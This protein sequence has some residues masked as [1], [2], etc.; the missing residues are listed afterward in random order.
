MHRGP[1]LVCAIVPFA[2]LQ[3]D[4]RVCSSMHVRTNT[5]LHVHVVGCMYTSITLA[6]QVRKP[7]V[8]IHF[9]A[10]PTPP[11]R[12]QARH[13]KHL[14]TR[15]PCVFCQGVHAPVQAYLSLVISVWGSVCVY[16]YVHHRHRV[17][18]PPQPLP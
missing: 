10:C 6:M 4:A 8:P 5:C 16:M 9:G 3:S 13:R 18:A 14:Q 7:A 17:F 15:S 12:V 1:V 11:L 2:W